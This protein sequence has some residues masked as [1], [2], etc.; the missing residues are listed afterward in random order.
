MSYPP[1]ADFFHPTDFSPACLSAFYHGLAMTMATRGALTIFHSGYPNE[2]YRQERWPRV[3][4][5]LA[6]WG[7]LEP[8]APREAVAELGVRIAKRQTSSSDPVAGIHKHA[9]RLDS[10]LLVLATHARVGLSRVLHKEVAAASMRALHRPGLFFPST[11]KS[12]V[13]FDTGRLKLERVLVAV[14]HDPAPAAALRAAARLVATFAASGGVCREV[15]VGAT[16]P[17]SERPEISGW[18]WEMKVLPA[19]DVDAEVIREATDWDADLIA[20]VSRGR[21][22]LADLFLGSTLDRVLHGSP[23]PV[24]AVPA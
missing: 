14:D 6:H 11:A 13:D 15:H 10:E 23:C 16:P 21:D 5:T 12:L 17:L 7:M 1:Y 4:A 19:G 24:L 20:M 8:G 18:T 2:G 22:H 9:A 3:R